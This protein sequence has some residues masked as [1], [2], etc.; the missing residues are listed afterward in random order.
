[1]TTSSPLL[2]LD[3]PAAVDRTA[4]P[5]A[6][7]AAAASGNARLSRPLLAFYR[8]LVAAGLVGAWQLAY[9]TKFVN[10]TFVA[11]PGRVLSTLVNLAHTRLW[12]D[13]WYTLST[14][15]MGFIFA[16]IVGV[17]VGFALGLMPRTETVVGGFISM[18]NAAPRLALA[19]LFVLWFG[20]GKE[21]HTVLVFSIVIFPILTNTIAGTQAVDR[22]HLLVA[23]LLGLG[24]AATVR[25]VILPSTLPWIIAAMR[26]SWAYALAGAVVSEM[27]LGQAGLGYLINAGSGLFNIAQIFAAIAVTV[28]LSWLVDR[29]ML[30]GE[31]HILRWRPSALTGGA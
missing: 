22:D 29:V 16:T 24:R 30:Y 19:P 7:A 23:R 3:D 17:A 10:Q 13:V 11:S 25:K 1:M 18:A 6:A 20:I 21:S 31:Q 27:F 14:A 5:A 8:L 26:L 2:D 9:S 12:S 4:E 15:L 28:V